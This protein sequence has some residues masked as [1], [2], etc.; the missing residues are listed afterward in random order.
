MNREETAKLFFLIKGSYPAYYK[1]IDEITAKILITS[2]HHSFMDIPAKVVFLLAQK[3]IMTNTFPPTIAELREQVIK[4][5][6]PDAIVTP[7]EAWEKV[8]LA[9]KK[10]GYYRQDEAFQSFTNPIK[11]AVKAIGWQ[12]ICMSENIGIERAN[13]FKMYNA[14][15]KD[16][17]EQYIMPK[18]ML[19]KLQ[20]L[21]HDK[22]VQKALDNQAN[23]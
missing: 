22:L 7:E 6:N 3:H 13:F 18:E 20:N 10:F 21:T 5:T 12:N 11:R 9:V 14:F 17:Q 15:E 16:K 2:W 8:I 1:D 23:D 19:V 4:A